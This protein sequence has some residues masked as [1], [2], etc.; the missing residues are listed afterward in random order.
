MLFVS[1][2]K[3]V[4][5]SRYRMLAREEK[6]DME[7]AVG[8]AQRAR[9]W[10]WADVVGTGVLGKFFVPSKA[11]FPHLCDGDKNTSIMGW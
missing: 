1:Q 9:V 4:A 11:Q 2:A 10:V 8:A 3:T 6:N 7:K 5:F